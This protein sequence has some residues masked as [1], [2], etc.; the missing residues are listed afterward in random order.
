MRQEELLARDVERAL[1]VAT[2]VELV[3]RRRAEDHESADLRRPRRLLSALLER[4]VRREVREKGPMEP[5]RVAVGERR[6]VRRQELHVLLQEQ[7]LAVGLV[8]REQR[9]REARD[10]RVQ[11]VVA[12]LHA[13]VVVVRS[14]PELLLALVRDLPDDQRRVRVQLHVR[15]RVLVRAVL[16]LRDALRREVRLDVR[17]RV[18]PV[19]GHAQRVRDEDSEETAL[20]APDQIALTHG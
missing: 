5:L 16:E 11:R 17:R 1:L 20:E 3:Q 7:L 13:V 9:E 6:R 2:P 18:D 4:L 12:G 15:V 14:V 8:L 10:L 19:H